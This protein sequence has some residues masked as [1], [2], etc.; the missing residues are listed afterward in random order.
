[1]A[2]WFPRGGLWAVSFW[3]AALLFEGVVHRILLYELRPS[4]ELEKIPPVFE[5][6]VPTATF[7]VYLSQILSFFLLFFFS[8]FILRAPTR[9]RF[10]RWMLSLILFFAFPALALNGLL[11]PTHMAGHLLWYYIGTISLLILTFLFLWHASLQFPTRRSV[12][13]Y[14]LLCSPSVLL[15]FSRLLNPQA[16]GMPGTESWAGTLFSTGN[17]LFLFQGLLW[18]LLTPAGSSADT[19]VSDPPEPDDLDADV[20]STEERK[21]AG[22]DNPKPGAAGP[23]PRPLDG[24]RA[25][26][27]PL[28]IS[29]ALTLAIA[30]FFRMDSSFATSLWFAGW[31]VSLPLENFWLFLYFLS[32]WASFYSIAMLLSSRRRWRIFLGILLMCWIVT[33]FSPYQEM[34]VLPFLALMTLLAI[35]TAFSS[36]DEH[37]IRRPRFD[38]APWV[39]ALGTPLTPEASASRLMTRHSGQLQ[40]VPV[41]LDV[42]TLKDGRLGGLRL[43]LGEEP[44]SEPDW[45]CCPISLVPLSRQ[46]FPTLPRVSPLDESSCTQVAIWDRNFFSED[47]LDDETLDSARRLLLGEVSVWWGQCLTY[48][49]SYLPAMGEDQREFCRYLALLAQ[50]AGVIDEPAEEPAAESQ[51]MIQAPS[52]DA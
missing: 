44:T 27:V 6:L 41:R 11:I 13:F 43:C 22:A 4:H 16:P 9:V 28:A 1:M 40:E 29:L 2:A 31:R 21:D 37:P 50:R 3:F 25:R 34:E 32:L 33:G 17:S 36:V 12:L 38:P 19:S 23:G 18:P 52:A 8:V 5:I 15:I 26:P 35:G 46:F 20:H 49:A 45:I 24:L 47:L 30:L 39:E 42:F 10:H 14:V 51:L 48:E 7:F